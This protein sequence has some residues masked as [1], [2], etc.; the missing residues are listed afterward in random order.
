MNKCYPSIRS[1][2]LPIHPL[3]TGQYAVFQSLAATERALSQQLPSTWLVQ[4]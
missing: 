2:L 3:D 1:V 4:A